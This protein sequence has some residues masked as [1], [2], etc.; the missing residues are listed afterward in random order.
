MEFGQDSRSTYL[1]GT[2]STIISSYLLHSWQLELK[3]QIFVTQTRV[4][5]PRTTRI[6]FHHR[7]KRTRSFIRILFLCP[8]KRLCMKPIPRVFINIHFRTVRVACLS[9]SSTLS[10]LTTM[11]NRSVCFPHPLPKKGQGLQSAFISVFNSGAGLK[12]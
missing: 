1:V 4:S 5:C 11:S 2:L 3:K 6:C 10:H 7:G 9:G 8:W 12:G